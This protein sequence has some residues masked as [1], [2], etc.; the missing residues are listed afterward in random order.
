LKTISE[1][2]SL[3]G[4]NALVT[5]ACGCL[6]KVISETLAELGC[7]LLLLDK[8]LDQLSIL[9]S[10]IKNAFQVKAEIIDCDLESQESRD[11]TIKKVSKLENLDILINNAAFVGSSNLHG[12]SEP[13]ELQSVDTWKR[14]LEVNLTSVFHL[15]QGCYSLLEK[16][17]G[18][19]INIGSI[20]G[21]L[22]PDWNLYNGTEM[23]N[24]AAY[25]AS[26]GGLIQ[27]T[28]WFSTTLAPKVRVNCISPGGIYRNQPKEF[29]ERYEAKTPL[30][31]MAYE[32]DFKGIITYLA[33]NMS[34]YTTGQNFIIDG[35][36]SIA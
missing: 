31:R 18:C 34:S 8:C 7:N 19:I 29:V 25:A 23:G 11:L 30:K 13:F 10:D 33:T 27:L 35:G 21:K 20:Y 28:R 4:R 9:E 22:G 36:Y 24:P 14:A 5:G 1:L 32:E 26:K 3:N 12:W 15:T 17:N 16:S 2:I 6:G